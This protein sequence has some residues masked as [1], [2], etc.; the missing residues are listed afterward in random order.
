MLATASPS[1][2][3]MAKKMAPFVA[4][5]QIIVDVSKGIEES[6]LMILTDVIEQEI[7]QCQAAVLSGP[8]HADEVG[9]DIPTTVVAGARKKQRNLSRIFS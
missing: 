4:E 9:R 8:S 2:R 6:T 3:N 1:I 7:P 5:G